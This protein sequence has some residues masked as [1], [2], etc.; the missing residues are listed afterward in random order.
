MVLSVAPLNSLSLKASHNKALQRAGSSE[1]GNA[2]R[3]KF[4]HFLFIISFSETVSDC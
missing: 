3:S 4:S 1:E 2:S